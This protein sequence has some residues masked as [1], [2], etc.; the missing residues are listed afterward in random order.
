MS[1]SLQKAW[2]TKQKRVWVLFPFMLLFALLSGLR[3]RFFTLGLLAVY[4]S[5]LPVVIVGNIGIGG[6]GKTPLAIALIEKLQAKGYRVALLSRGYGGSQTQFPYRLH[7]GDTAALVG[8]EPALIYH[9]LHCD[10]IIDPKRARGARFIE[11]HTDANIIICD[12][13]LQ[14]YALARDVELCVVDQRGIGNAHLLPMGPLREGPWRLQTVDAVVHNLAMS[15]Q[16]EYEKISDKPSFGMSLLAKS[17]INVKTNEQLS[18]DDFSRMISK[19]DKK[20]SK[21]IVSLAGIGDPKRF[22]QSLQS[23]HIITNK[24]IA[25]AD[26]H[27]F[28]QSDIPA[29]SLV[30]MTEKDAVKC[31]E[32]AHIDCWYLAIDA[33]LPTSFYTLVEQRIQNRID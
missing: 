2:Y 24:N 27:H 17:W 10:V 22:F 20:K 8:D 16:K 1:T 28:T 19:I 33:Q 11:E 7:A 4:K 26:H 25:F 6:N 9:R 18:I 21:S 32:F 31:T 15:A 13:G 14:H 3:R 29:D 12:D 5:K 23:M 30:L